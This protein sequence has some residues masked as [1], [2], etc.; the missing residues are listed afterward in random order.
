MSKELLDEL[1]EKDLVIG[2]VY[3]HTGECQVF[4]FEKS[5]VNIASF[6]MKHWEGTDRIVLTNQIDKL[7]LNT[8]GQFINQCPDQAF[9]QK[10]LK[11]LLPMQMGE[12]EPDDILVANEKEFQELLYKEDQKVTEA[13]LR[14]L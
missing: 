11:E 1:L 13:E 2:Y 10:V 5:P 3:G 9:L 12:K 8:F 7:L 4:Y 14:M 6:I